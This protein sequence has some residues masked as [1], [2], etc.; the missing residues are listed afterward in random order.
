MAARKKK[1]PA[2]K[3]P[4]RRARRRK[5]KE[6]WKPALAA[7]AGGVGTA[8]II[9]IERESRLSGNT[10]DKSMLILEGLLRNLYASEQ[11]LTL[12]ASIAMEQ[13]YGGI[14]G[15]SATVAEFLCLLSAISEVPLRQDLAVTGS[16]NQWGE[17]RNTGSLYPRLQ[18]AEPRPAFRCHRRHSK[19]TVPHLCHL[20]CEPGH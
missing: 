9:N 14:D 2:K 12:S 4:A 7:L 15:D 5:K 10:Y 1:T 11:P 20:K 8:G 18:R 16:V 13:S 3:A 19:E 6:T 17:V